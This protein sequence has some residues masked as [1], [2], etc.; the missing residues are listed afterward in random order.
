[1][2]KKTRAT[3]IIIRAT[4]NI[5]GFKEAYNIAASKSIEII[6]LGS[7]AA[8]CER[9]DSDIDILFVGDGK[10]KKTRKLDFIWIKPDKINQKSWLGSELANHVASY[11][12]W[13]KGD[14]TWRQKV[15]ISETSI[16]R[17]KEAI[18]VR[19]IHL[20]LKRHKYRQYS[21]QKLFI[22]VLLDFYRLY[23]LTS[24]KA[25]PPTKMVSDRIKNQK[26]NLISLMLNDSYLGAV[27]ATL[28]KEIFPNND[29]DSLFLG[30]KK[31]L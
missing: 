18:Y 15:F 2:G 14:G 24:K 6:L 19:L 28:L 16:S 31:M 13:I 30:L 25:I 4:Q 23:L 29:L 10:R 8:G 9:A 27:G 12:L 26:R 11:G 7:Y 17:K 3:N 20:Y 21:I 1:M 5:P 22:K